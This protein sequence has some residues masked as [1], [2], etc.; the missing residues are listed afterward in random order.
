MAKKALAECSWQLLL[1]WWSL[2]EQGHELIRARLEQ[3]RVLVTAGQQP[4]TVRA[5][6][7]RCS[8]GGAQG[9]APL[10]G[11]VHQSIDCRVRVIF[12]AVKEVARPA[13]PVKSDSQA[14]HGSG[15]GA[16]KG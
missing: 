16:T 4:A 1:G 10:L 15:A 11:I 9:L 7:R 13:A 8:A 2:G 14:A 6:G 5:N 12:E 3:L